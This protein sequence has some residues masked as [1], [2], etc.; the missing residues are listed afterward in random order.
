MED[1]LRSIKLLLEQ[2]EPQ[3]YYPALMLSLATIDICAAL[4]S[5]DG[6][7]CRQSYIKW[8]EKTLSSKYPYMDGET[9]YELRCGVVH[10]GSS[11]RD[12]TKHLRVV[13]VWGSSR[14][15]SMHNNI[16]DDALQL[17]LK[18]FCSDIRDAVTG[19]L[20]EN[21]NSENDIAKNIQENL[22]KLLKYYPEGLPPYTKGIPIIA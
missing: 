17:D 8:F 20:D 21:K 2:E 19:W 22:P 4:E 10:E 11:K 9:C 18:Q 5:S 7:T 12:K 15:V 6:K 13:F 14:G 16:M 3:F 1:L